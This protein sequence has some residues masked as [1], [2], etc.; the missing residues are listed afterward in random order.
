V[1]GRYTWELEDGQGLSNPA[2]GLIQATG[3]AAAAQ[4]Q[5][6]SQCGGKGGNCAEYGPVLMPP[7]VRG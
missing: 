7:M 4:L 2:A 5:T 1:G 6:W 3:A